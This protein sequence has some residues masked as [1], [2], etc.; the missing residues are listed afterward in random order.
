MNSQKIS[1]YLRHNI[2]RFQ[3]YFNTR[4]KFEIERNSLTLEVVIDKNAK[5]VKKLRVDDKD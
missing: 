3:L 1:A 4:Y 5:I 2:F